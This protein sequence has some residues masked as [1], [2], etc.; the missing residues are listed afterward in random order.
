MTT[1]EH[2]EEIMQFA[3]TAAWEALDAAGYPPRGD[4]KPG[5]LR[6]IGLELAICEPHWLFAGWVTDRATGAR[7]TFTYVSSGAR[8]GN[9]R[10]NRVDDFTSGMVPVASRTLR[11]A[12]VMVFGG[13]ELTIWDAA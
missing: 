5:T 13:A 8:K 6:G 9:P 11:D 7:V 1:I 4:A 2:T 12:G 3:Q 10:H